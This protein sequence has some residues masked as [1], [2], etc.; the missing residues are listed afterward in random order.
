[1]S[2]LGG[3]LLTL[4]AQTVPAEPQ[5]SGDARRGYDVLVNGGYV[6]CGIPLSLYREAFGTGR[7][8]LRGRRGLN[9]QL[10]YYVTATRGDSGATVVAANCLSCHAGWLNGRLVVGLGEANLD[11][12]FRVGA[13]G[14]LASLL[15]SRPSE[16]RELAK[17]L[18]VIDAV[19]G[20]TATDTLGV[21]SADKL[22]ALLMAHRDPST[23]AWKSEALSPVPEQLAPIKVPAWWLMRRK[24]AMFFTGSGRGDHARLMMASALLCTDNVGQAQEIDRDFGDVREY[25][26]SLRAPPY[27][28]EVDRALAASGA[29]VYAIHC[30]SCHGS[31]DPDGSYPNRVIAASAV[32]TDPLLWEQSQAA[33]SQRQWFAHSFFGQTARLEATAGYVAPPLDGVW[34]RAPYL[35]NGSVPTLAALLDSRARPRFWTRS[36]RSSDYDQD[37]AGWR[38]TSLRTGR[39]GNDS[40]RVYD[41]T[42]PGFSNAGH[43]YGDALDVDDRRAL[44]EF[45]KTL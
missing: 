7:S 44:L 24:T 28:Y 38:F 26:A 14:H 18:R 8:E 6:R 11:Q 45:L 23:L 16:Q 36:F 25:I 20:P 13:M 29:P 43:A 34:A 9:A 40:P 35:H 31:P 39:K 27:P 41:T 33:G 37:Q 12:T 42:R 19:E 10:P 21:S 5:R 1:M 4:L 32:G 17:F 22:A 15:V 2:A 3:V 30:Q